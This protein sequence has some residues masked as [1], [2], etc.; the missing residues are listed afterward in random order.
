MGTPP[1]TPVDWIWVFAWALFLT[2]TVT[3]TCLLWLGVLVAVGMAFPSVVIRNLDLRFMTCLGP[4]PC[5][6]KTS[7]AFA[8]VHQPDYAVLAI[9]RRKGAPVFLGIPLDVPLDELEEFL[10]G[11]GLE[12]WVDADAVPPH[13]L[14]ATR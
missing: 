7:Q 9:H 10:R 6:W 14:A 12:P 5:S 11:R 4:Q 13:L 8:I 3:A 1:G 2:H